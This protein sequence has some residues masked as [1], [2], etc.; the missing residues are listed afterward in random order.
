MDDSGPAAYARS[1]T[2][3]SEGDASGDEAAAV[4]SAAHAATGSLQSTMCAL[5]RAEAAA[6]SASGRPSRC[7][8][9]EAPKEPNQLL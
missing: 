1:Q 5:Q 9:L 6:A 7:P 8:L 2:S 4:A 3:G